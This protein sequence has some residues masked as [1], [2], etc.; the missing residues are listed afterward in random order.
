M[1]MVRSIFSRQRFAM[2]FVALLV[3]VDQLVKWLV[4]RSLPYNEKVGILPSLALYRT[5]NDGIAFS[6]LS[7][8]GDNI[9]IVVT[10]AIIAFVTWLWARSTPSRWISQFGFVLIISGAIGNLIDRAMDG[11]VIDYILFYVQSWSF[12]V[13]NLADAFITIGAAAIIIDELFGRWIYD[14]EA[15]GNG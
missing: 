12:A 7:G 14:A 13:F 15:A 6:M 2:A 5:H 9:L 8:F 11:Y 10:L 1:N 4:E 3:A